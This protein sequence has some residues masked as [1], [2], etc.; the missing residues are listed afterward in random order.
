MKVITPDF[1]IEK[2][3]GGQALQKDRGASKV[4]RIHANGKK[5]G[6]KDTLESIYIVC[7]MN[8][9]LEYGVASLLMNSRRL[10]NGIIIIIIIITTRIYFLTNHKVTDSFCF[11]SWLL[12]YYYLLPNVRFFLYLDYLVD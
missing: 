4:R 6:A 12:P 1:I 9:S 11:S 8:D 2:R 3:D 5:F 7:E 10:T